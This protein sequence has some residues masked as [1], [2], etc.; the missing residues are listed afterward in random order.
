MQSGL[1]LETCTSLHLMPSSWP[2]LHMSFHEHAAQVTPEAFHSVVAPYLDQHLLEVY[3]NGSGAA[4]SDAAT[5]SVLLKP[6]SL[7]GSGSIASDTAATPAA[8]FASE[9]K[10]GVGFVVPVVV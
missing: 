1:A 7:R 2:R 9:F 5:I 4:S 3:R 6:G 10:Q 8:A